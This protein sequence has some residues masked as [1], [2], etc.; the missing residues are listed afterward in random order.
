M[1]FAVDVNPKDSQF[2]ALLC[3]IVKLNLALVTRSCDLSSYQ[4]AVSHGPAKFHR[5]ALA[6]VF[7]WPA[8]IPEVCHEVS[9]SRPSWHC[10]RIYDRIYEST[11][12]WLTPCNKCGALTEVLQLDPRIR[13]SDSDGAF[14]CRGCWKKRG[15]VP[16]PEKK[17]KAAVGTRSARA[18]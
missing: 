7:N 5:A 18:S 3:C 11:T 1:E 14:Y 8:W 16:P 9:G 15:C 12:A 4:F 13:C 10:S 6:A 2:S 17:L